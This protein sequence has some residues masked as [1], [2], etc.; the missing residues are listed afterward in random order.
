MADFGWACEMEPGEVRTSLCGTYAYMSPEII[1]KG[2]HTN[3]AD[4]WALGILLYEMLHGN[5]PNEAKKIEDLKIFLREK[6]FR[7]KNELSNDIR[8]L[9]NVLLDFDDNERFNI[10]RILEL[11]FLQSENSTYVL[12]ADDKKILV[13]NFLYNTNNN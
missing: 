1:L 9:F 2:I 5:P 13:E 6:K 12:S 7:F 11:P 8:N 10:N 4:I 3:K